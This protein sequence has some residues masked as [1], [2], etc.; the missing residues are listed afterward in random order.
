M[1]SLNKNFYLPVLKFKQGELLAIMHL[2]EEAKDRVYPLFEVMP[3]PW[4]YANDVPAKELRAHLSSVIPNLK[5]YW[6]GRPFMIDFRFIREDQ[7]TVMPPHPLHSM[8]QEAKDAGLHMVPVVSLGSPTCFLEGTRTALKI[9]GHGA[10]LRI[11]GE[12][13]DNPNFDADIEAMLDI[14]LDGIKAE[15]VDV[16]VDLGQIPSEGL[17]PLVVGMRNLMRMVPPLPWRSLSMVASSF[18]DNLSE[19]PSASGGYISRGE[20][21]LW[22]GMLE[23]PRRYQPNFGD[24]TVVNPLPFEM[25]P[26][27]MRMGAKVK[28]TTTDSWLIVKGRGIKGNGFEQFRE[29]SKQ[30]ME[31]KDYCGPEFSWGDDYIKKCAEGTEG[32]GNQTTWVRV[33]VNHH[34][35][36]VLDQL[37]KRTDS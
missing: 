14:Q 16:V 27:L 36:F 5:K 25:D 22:T 4:D 12:D 33:G 30:I 17:T 31:L 1:S 24:Y 8:A 6:D 34:M 15:D 29:L 11:V 2:H 35:E 37:A 19:I 23:K 7:C 26:R 21:K 32:P 18:P 20:W 9:L 13:F 3:I 10:A 28:Y